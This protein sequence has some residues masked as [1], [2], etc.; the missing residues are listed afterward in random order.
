MSTTEKKSNQSH[1]ID[2][3]GD[4]TVE[5]Q[6]SLVIP[7]QTYLSDQS[8]EVN[9]SSSLGTIAIRI[10]DENENIVYKKSVD[11][12]SIQQIFIN[13]TSFVEG[14]YTIEFVNSQNQ[15]LSGNFKI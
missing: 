1:P 15:Y 10:Y 2:L 8:I 4:F 13:I 7:I 6:R 11:T 12:Y 3:D 5:K 9:F 14:V